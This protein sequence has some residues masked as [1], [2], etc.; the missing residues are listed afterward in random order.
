MVGSFA[1]IILR[2]EDDGKGFDVHNRLVSANK[3]GRMGLR[4]MEERA[5]LLHGKMK[6]ESHPKQGTK[7]MVEVPYKERIIAGKENH[8]DS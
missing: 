1:K 3:E 2:I 8:L 6:I 4:I 5:S 7:I